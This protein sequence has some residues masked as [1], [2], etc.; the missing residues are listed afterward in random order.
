MTK[1]SELSLSPLIV[2]CWQLDDRSWAA[3]SEVDIRRSID[4]YLAL[5]VTSFDTADIYGRSER[6]LGQLLKGRKDCTI[7]TKAVFATTIPT[8]TQIRHKIESSLRNLRRER[9][10]CVQVHWHNPEVDFASTFATLQ[11]L[12]EHGRIHKLGVTNFNTSM[13]EKALRY[14]PIHTHQVQYSLIDRRVELGMQDF[15]QRQ[16][17]DLLTYGPL[18]G[19]YLSDKF[20]Q[21]VHPPADINHARGFY[22]ISMIQ[23]HGGWALVGQMLETLTKIAK[24]YN[25]TVA[26]VALS[27]VRHQLGVKAVISGLTL[28][29]QQIQHNV[30]AVHWRMEEADMQLL[31]QRSAQLFKQVGDIYSYERRS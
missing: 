16:Q 28:N 13:L 21:V 6:L 22:Y 27:W 11:E 14:A 18:A 24:K 19:G 5:G 25:K 12:Q 1:A 17:I 30:A 26:Q 8:P 31:S 15:C 20:W 10:D 23:A 29:R 3:L 2:G 4:T 9:L 7:L